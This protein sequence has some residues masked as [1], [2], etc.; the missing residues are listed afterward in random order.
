M[1]WSPLSHGRSRCR[2]RRFHHEM[3]CRNLDGA[4]KTLSGGLSIKIVPKGDRCSLCMTQHHPIHA[5]GPL[6]NP[7]LETKLRWTL[8][9]RNLGR[10]TTERLAADA[11]PSRTSRKAS[12]AAATQLLAAPSEFPTE[13]LSFIPVRGVWA[14]ASSGHSTQQLVTSRSAPEVLNVQCQRASLR[15]KQVEIKAEAV[16]H[17]VL[18]RLRK[19]FDIEMNPAWQN[20]KLF[21]DGNRSLYLLLRLTDRPLS[22]KKMSIRTA[23]LPE[24]RP[25]MSSGLCSALIFG[26]LS[27]HWT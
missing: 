6:G 27:P 26:D 13:I 21:N 12:L 19:Q 11:P 15:L 9:N 20:S 23:C 2:H 14:E 24:S 25:A 8:Y 1:L 5:L 16:A 7:F 10:S 18:A 3:G 17:D 22:G 4:T